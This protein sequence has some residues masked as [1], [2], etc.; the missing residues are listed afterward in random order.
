MSAGFRKMEI[1]QNW[2]VIRFLFLDNKRSRECLTL[3]KLNPR[4][5]CVVS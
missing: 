5:L 1:E 2:S 4:G 3:F